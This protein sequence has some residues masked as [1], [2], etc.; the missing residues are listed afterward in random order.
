MKSEKD[1]FNVFFLQKGDLGS[2]L[3]YLF[4]FRLDKKF[5]LYDKVVKSDTYLTPTT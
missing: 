1:F 2:F 5:V 3:R 4:F